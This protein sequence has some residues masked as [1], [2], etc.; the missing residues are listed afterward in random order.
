MNTESNAI[1]LEGASNALSLNTE[2]SCWL[3]LAEYGDWPHARG[4]QRFSKESADRMCAYFRSLRG[5]LARKFGGL[6]VYIGHPD[7]P[8]FSGQSGH[9]DTRAY[10]WISELEARDN[11]LYGLPRWSE[12]GSKLLSNA[13]YK[14]LSPRWAMRDVG[15]GVYEPVRLLSVGLTNQPNIPGETIANE[16]ESHA[17][18]IELTRVLEVLELGD[19]EDPVAACEAL[20]EECD[21]LRQSNEQLTA[22]NDRFYRLANDHDTAREEAETA[23]ANERQLRISLLLDQAVAQGRILPN[24]REERMTEMLAD[25][26]GGL[27]DIRATQPVLK[28][29]CVS[30]FLGQ[31]KGGL[32][33]RDEFLALVNERSASSGAGFANAWNQVKQERPELFQMLNADH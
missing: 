24:E 2:S 21:F 30:G 7:D 15:N 25:L 19:A 4:L 5:R 33:R 31:R 28:T 13:F 10:A 11:G 22:E 17:E 18:E 20:R 27:A 12:E 8:H 1:E 6:P 26:P 23:L 3:C 32:S 14:F 16:A 9:A 29:A